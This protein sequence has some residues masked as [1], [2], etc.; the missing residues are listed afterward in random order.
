[1]DGLDFKN[2]MV[3]LSKKL[4]RILIQT[5]LSKAFFFFAMSLIVKNE[6]YYELWYHLFELVDLYPKL[7]GWNKGF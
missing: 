5:F 1:M 7:L 6:F 3:E 2:S 4:S